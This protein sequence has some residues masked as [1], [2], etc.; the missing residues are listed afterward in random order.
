MLQIE[1]ALHIKRVTRSVQEGHITIISD[2][3]ALYPAQEWPSDRVK[4]VGK[5]IWKGGK[6]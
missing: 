2:N 5:V 4:V 6:V 1:D 3:K